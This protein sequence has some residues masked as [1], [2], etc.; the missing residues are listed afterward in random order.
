MSPCKCEQW[1]TGCWVQDSPTRVTEMILQKL[2][3]EGRVGH[4]YYFSTWLSPCQE[5]QNLR[6][7]RFTAAGRI[8]DSWNWL[9]VLNAFIY[10]TNSDCLLSSRHYDG[11]R[12]TLKWET[13]LPPSGSLQ[14]LETCSKEKGLDVMSMHNMEPR[15]PG[16]EKSGMKY[17]HQIPCPVNFHS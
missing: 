6:K 12:D 5:I 7:C 10:P 2:K 3:D 8:R 11:P 17:F 9:L 14:L 16:E 15:E 4:G 13:W 1:I